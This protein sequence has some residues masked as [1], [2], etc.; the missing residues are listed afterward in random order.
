MSKIHPVVI[1]GAGPAG[2]GISA[3]LSQCAITSVILERGEIGE[4]FYL[5]PQETRFI[6]PSFTG[7]FFGAVDLNAVTPFTSPAYS[8]QT[9]H[10]TGSQYAQYLNGVANIHSLKV[11]ECVEVQDFEVDKKGIFCLATNEGEMRARVVIW[12]GGESQ[13]PKSIPHTVRVGSSYEEFPKGHHVVIGGAESGMEATFN[14]VQNG[15]TVTVIDPSSPWAER[16]SDSSYGLSPY[17]FDRVRFLKEGG[18]VTFIAEHAHKVTNS[19]V[20]TDNHTFS[21]AHPAIDATGFD[22][23]R[24]LAGKL[25]NFPNGYPELTECDESTKLKNVYLVGS[26]VRHEDAIFCFIYKYRQRF[27]VVV[28]EILKRWGET[29]PVINEYEE[30]GFLLDDLSCCDGECAC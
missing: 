2:I 20:L 18:N 19:E 27:A 22:I 17:T 5:W 29:S 25:F 8:L 24:G 11:E 6:S 7:N 12:A 15:S 16:V 21:L 28:R 1:V 3:L 30:R 23:Q 10:P 14:L 4:S 9:E 26:H 13:Y